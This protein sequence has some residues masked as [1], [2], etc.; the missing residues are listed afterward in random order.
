MLL[1]FTFLDFFCLQC[2]GV[3]CVCMTWVVSVPYKGG[4]YRLI[5]LKTSPGKI[6]QRTRTSRKNNYSYGALNYFFTCIIP[7]KDRTFFRCF[8]FCDL[9]L[10]F[11]SNQICFNFRRK[12]MYLSWISWDWPFNPHHQ[13]YYLNSSDLLK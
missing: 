4:L 2:M 8:L 7:L 1:F 3:Y 10:P 11:P 5:F 6:T 9:Q 13:T 12:K